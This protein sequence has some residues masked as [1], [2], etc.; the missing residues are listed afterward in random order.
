MG[1]SRGVYLPRQLVE[2]VG[3]CDD[4]A[5]QVWCKGD[6]VCIRAIPDAG[7]RQEVDT[8]PPKSWAEHDRDRQLS[9]FEVRE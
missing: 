2:A 9:I 6:T 8:T 1:D 4:E 3:W 5:L 7:G